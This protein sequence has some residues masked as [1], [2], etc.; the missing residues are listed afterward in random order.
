[1][2]SLDL[3]QCS[4]RKGTASSTKM[5]D[6]PNRKILRRDMLFAVRYADG[7]RAFMLEVDRASEPLRSSAARSHLAQSVDQY[8][9]MFADDRHRLHYGL[10]ASTAVL[11]AFSHP[12]RMHAFQN[13]VRERAGR[14]AGHVL[15]KAMPERLEWAN[16]E[17]LHHK[18]WVSSFGEEIAGL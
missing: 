18:S 6:N 14:W 2:S 5:H 3:F 12:G 10:K 8:A 16:L 11:W 7:F 9:A 13:L 17:E 1:M 4:V 15:C